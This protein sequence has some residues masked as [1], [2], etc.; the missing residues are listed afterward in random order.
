MTQELDTPRLADSKE[1]PPV[2]TQREILVLQGMIDGLTW[3]EFDA[4]F[5]LKRIVLKATKDSIA[6]RFT[7][8]GHVGG[9]YLAIIEAIKQDLLVTSNLPKEYR[10]QLTKSEINFFSMQYKGTRTSEVCESLGIE[11]REIPSYRNRICEKLGVDKKLGVGNF[12]AAIACLARDN[13][14]ADQL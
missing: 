3:Q 4:K 10:G 6:A 13:K 7:Q 12:F 8:T 2:F 1:S 11:M 9:I 5:D 14:E